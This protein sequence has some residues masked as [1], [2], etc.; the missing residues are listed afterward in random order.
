M[1]AISSH[2]QH[3]KSA[4]VA[5]NQKLAW[6]TWQSYF[7][8]VIY[9]GPEEPE[10]KSQ[11][12]TFIASDDFPTIKTM[13]GIA[14]NCPG[15]TAILNA[16]ILV[17]PKLNVVQHRLQNG[18][19][20]CGSSRR[21][22]FDI[23]DLPS[24]EKAH[25]IDTDRGRDIFV[26]TQRIWQRAAKEIPDHLRIGHQQWDAWMTDFFN[27]FKPGF[28][29]FTQMKCIFHPYHGDRQMPFAEQIVQQSA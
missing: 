29:D 20:V 7:S 21:W 25:L 4:E 8:G 27:T 2:R 9:L 17:N 3:S 5:R 28:V 18:T 26:A 11:K 1:I 22:H 14:A 10:L 19:S 23:K 12:T 16:D 6:R 13:A 15:V 24:L